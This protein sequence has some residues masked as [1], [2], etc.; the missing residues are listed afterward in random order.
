[1]LSNTKKSCAEDKVFPHNFRRLFA[2]TFYSL[3]KGIVR[4]A[5]I[6]NLKYGTYENAT[7]KFEINGGKFLGE[8]FDGIATGMEQYAC[9]D[10]SISGGTYTT[11]VS[12][13]C[14]D[15]YAA[16]KDEITGEYVVKKTLAW[17]TDTDSGSYV[18]GDKKYAMMRFMF[19]TAPEGEVTA[20]GIKYINASDIAA[21]PTV[22]GAVNTTNHSSIFQGDIVKVPEGKTGTY[23][24]KAYVT[25]AE[26]TF[27]S[28][29]VGCSVNWD[30]FF[31]DYKEGQE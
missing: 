10:I 14:K 30:R 24:A 4:L 9:K 11:N 31:A 19:K 7:G 6:L 3:Q 22:D 2:R 15:G 28:E 1:M 20:S 27:W 17:E 16:E 5:D 26:G 12:E 8:T 23:Y 13:Y 21:V 25:T 18:L 29:A